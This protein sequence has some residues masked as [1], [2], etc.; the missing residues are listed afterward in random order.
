MGVLKDVDYVGLFL[1][2]HKCKLNEFLAPRMGPELAVFRAIIELFWPT[3]CLAKMAILNTVACCFKKALQL[4]DV[5]LLTAEPL[6][7]PPAAAADP[8]D[9]SCTDMLRAQNR[10]V[11]YK[12]QFPHQHM[13]NVEREIY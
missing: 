1:Q 6:I 11:N 10:I 8:A 4:Y 9:D 7:P 5:F 2:T 3:L 13:A 12:N